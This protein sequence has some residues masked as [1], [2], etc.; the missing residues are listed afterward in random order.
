M[1]QGKLLGER[2]FAFFFWTQFLGA[3]N[4][5][6]FKNALIILFTLTPPRDVPLSRDLLVNLAS[7]MLVLP[8]FLFS[9][10][11]GQLAE[12]MEKSRLIRATKLLEVVL[13]VVACAAFVIAHLW[14]RA[15]GRVAR[16]PGAGISDKAAAA[17]PVPSEGTP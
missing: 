4:D 9:A 3:F 17:V 5:N 12:K 8:F 14:A 1:S 10:T 7:G 6:L 2:R 11:A 13:M 16:R 15:P